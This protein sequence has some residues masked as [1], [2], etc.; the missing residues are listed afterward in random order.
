MYILKSIIMGVLLFLIL[1]PVDIGDIPRYDERQILE[2]AMIQ[3]PECELETC[4]WGQEG[5]TQVVK[6]E[7]AFV[8][9]YVGDNKWKVIK[10]CDINP[11]WSG[12]WDFDEK[13]GQFIW[14]DEYYNLD[15]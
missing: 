7:P 2:L 13:T 6:E 3:S 11:Q 8:I 4:G 12:Y 1:F 15:N 14:N 5:P 9:E 10:H